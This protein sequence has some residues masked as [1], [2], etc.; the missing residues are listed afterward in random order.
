LARPGYCRAVHHAALS[1]AATIGLSVCWGAFAV[2]W[3][4]GAFY[5]ASSGPAPQTSRAPFGSVMLI[6]FVVVWIAYRAFPATDWRSLVVEAAWVRFLGLA[7]LLG[8]TAFTLWARFALG[9]MW[10]S[11]PMVKQGH[12][13]RTDGPYSV[14]RHPIYTGILGMLL[15]STLLLAVGRWVLLFPVFLVL[16][17]V[18]IHMEEQ[19]LLAQFPDDY[20]SY[21]TR[22]PQL[23]PGIPHRSGGQP[24]QR[25]GVTSPT[26][27]SSRRSATSWTRSSRS[28]AAGGRSRGSP[29]PGSASGTPT[30]WTWRPVRT[31]CCSWRLPWPWTGSS[32]TRTSGA[33]RGAWQR[34]G[35]C[36][37]A[38]SAPATPLSGNQARLEP[39]HDQVSC[40]PAPVIRS[41]TST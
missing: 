33:S 27:A 28:P 17:L 18:K 35:A 11:A 19:L 31:T 39:R 7:I 16:Y 29:A 21:R 15:G 3:L 37:G 40:Q 20:P 14:T 12:Q 32:T 22:V 8:A 5:N 10:S 34:D 38:V 6:G 41:Y 36:R 4:A 24:R 2:T 23:V 13:L 25:P 9:M 1:L 26:A 30:G